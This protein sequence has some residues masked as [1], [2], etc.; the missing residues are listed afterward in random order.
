MVNGRFGAL[1]FVDGALET[2]GSVEIQDGLVSAVYLMRNPDKLG[3][4][5]ATWRLQR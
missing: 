3:G 5:A 2:V 4:A 1:V